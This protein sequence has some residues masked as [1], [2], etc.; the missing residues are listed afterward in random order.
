MRAGPVVITLADQFGACMNT[1]N[2]A[3][4]R[5]GYHN[6]IRQIAGIIAERPKA[7][8]GCYDGSPA[9]LNDLTLRRISCVRDV[10]QHTE[11]VHFRN[12]PLAAFVDT[13][14]LGFASYGGI[15]VSRRHLACKLD[16][17]HPK[18]VPKSQNVDI[19]V[20][21]ETR[22]DTQYHCQLAV[23]D[24]SSHIRAA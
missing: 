6:V 8:V 14:P 7:D 5:K 20:L 10:D 16:N 18:A 13:A 9:G 2:T 21:I 11:A 24:D 4:F 3:L 22:L 19:A 15:R 23:R 1:D 17:A 12:Q